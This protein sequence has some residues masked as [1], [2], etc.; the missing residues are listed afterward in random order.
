MSIL[1]KGLISRSK[2]YVPTERLYHQKFHRSEVMFQTELRN[3]RQHEN[4]MQNIFDL[5]GIK[6][7]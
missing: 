4:I 1:K 7:S 5:R 2:G 6:I 3:D